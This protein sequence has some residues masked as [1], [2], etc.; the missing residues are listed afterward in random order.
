MPVCVSVCVYVLVHSSPLS[1]YEFHLLF[2]TTQLSFFLLSP[3]IHFYSPPAAAD[4]SAVDSL[5]L[6]FF[7]FFSNFLFTL[8]TLTSSI[9][10]LLSNT[11]VD[12]TR[13]AAAKKMKMKRSFSSLLSFF[14]PSFSFYGNCDSFYPS[15]MTPVMVIYPFIRDLSTSLYI[16]QAFRTKI[17]VKYT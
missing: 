7:T 15:V 6:L 9:F 10:F 13:K 4:A 16:I 1:R 17:T 8:T 12:L 2:S 5:G 3:M 14:H 11:K